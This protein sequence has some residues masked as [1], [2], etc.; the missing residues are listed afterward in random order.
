MYQKKKRVKIYFGQTRIML[1]F[2]FDLFD[3]VKILTHS[4]WQDI[5]EK[6]VFPLSVSG[7][8]NMLCYI[9]CIEQLIHSRW[10][11]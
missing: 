4:K 11:F 8:V 6:Q 9:I 1:R 2:Y 7:F 10:F 5:D 3:N